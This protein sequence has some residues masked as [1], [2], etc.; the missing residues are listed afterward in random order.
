VWRIATA[1]IA[2]RGCR[3]CSRRLSPDA[4]PEVAPIHLATV[5]GDGYPHITPLWFEWDGEAFWMTSLPSKA[6]IK[7]LRVDPRASVCL[8]IEGP[9]Q[10]DGERPNQQVRALGSAELLD[11]ISG[12]RTRSI[13]YRY[14]HGEGRTDMVNRRSTQP[15]ITVR[16]APT[17]VIAV[18]SV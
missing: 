3:R 10:P 11:D 5:D 12:E 7:R 8:D 16:L 6:H 4:R 17:D 2:M 9:E 1:Q 18:A 15:R 13:T 14:L